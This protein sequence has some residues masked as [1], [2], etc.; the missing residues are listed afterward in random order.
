[1]DELRGKYLFAFAH[2]LHITPPTVDALRYLDFIHLILE[3]D[4]YY[5]AKKKAESR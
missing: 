1:V 2:L 4:A 5:E 3:I